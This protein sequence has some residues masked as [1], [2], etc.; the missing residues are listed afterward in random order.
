M[1]KVKVARIRP[2][3]WNIY[4]QGREEAEYARS[5]LANAGLQTSYLQQQPDLTEPPS[6][7]F[8]VTPDEAT[9]MTS[10]ELEAILGQ[11]ERVEL[12]F[13]EA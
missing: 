2:V 12:M 4:V 7:V 1:D 13:D 3:S 6:Y 5:L 11:D 8:L 9:P 10:T